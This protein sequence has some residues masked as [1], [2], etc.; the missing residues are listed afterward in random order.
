MEGVIKKC[1]RVFDASPP[2]FLLCRTDENQSVLLA[3]CARNE[4]FSRSG[5]LC[6]FLRNDWFNKRHSYSR[7]ESRSR[8]ALQASRSAL[9]FAVEAIA[10]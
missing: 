7:G 6:V 4:H 9:Y 8:K 10:P 2:K 1:V 5:A 3:N